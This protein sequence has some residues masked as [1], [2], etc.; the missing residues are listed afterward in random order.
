MKAKTTIIGRG[1][2]GGA[3]CRGLQHAGYD[4]VTTG[5]DP[6]GV[7]ELAQWGDMIV[8][9]VPFSALDEAIRSMDG[10]ADCCPGAPDMPPQGMLRRG[11]QLRGRL[12]R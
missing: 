8:L 7:R 1:N 12:Q 11:S 4:M 9:A 5:S 6:S 3:L 10:A 2:V